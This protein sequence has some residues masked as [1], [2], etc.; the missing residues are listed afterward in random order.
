MFELLLGLQQAIEDGAQVKA[1]IT[2]L[3]PFLGLFGFWA[4]VTGMG[5]QAHGFT[6]VQAHFLM[7]KQKAR[8]VQ[9]MWSKEGQV[10]D[11]KC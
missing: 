2:D 11:A 6:H 9:S 8:E 4:Y 5:M 7:Y 10:C 1:E 3:D